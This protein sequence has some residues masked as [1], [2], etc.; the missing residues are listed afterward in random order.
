MAGVDAGAVPRRC[1]ARVSVVAVFLDDSGQ[2]FVAA[3]AAE[4]EGLGPGP[5]ADGSGE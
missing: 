1:G 3:P 4:G 2:V 5:G